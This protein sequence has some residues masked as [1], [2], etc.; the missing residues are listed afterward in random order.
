MPVARSTI[1]LILP[2]ASGNPGAAAVGFRPHQRR[3]AGDEPG[4]I[5]FRHIEPGHQGAEVGQGQQVLGRIEVP[6]GDQHHFGDPPREGGADVGPLQFEAGRFQ[7]RSGEV[8]VE[9]R[10]LVVV[11]RDQILLEGALLPGVLGLGA[12]EPE[13]G[14][15]E[16]EPPVAGVH[17]GQHRAGRRPR[18]PPGPGS[19]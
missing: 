12:G 6:A 10:L 15:L 4:H 18:R 11:F 7:F 14:L 1:G 17:P 13:L 9:T 5:P 2:D 3:L 19:R 8:A 16:G